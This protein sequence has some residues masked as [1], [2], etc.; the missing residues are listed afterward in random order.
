MRT[1]LI[2]LGTIVTLILV[3]LSFYS[4]DAA[5]YAYVT[6]LGRHLA[7]YDGAD[8]EDGAG[9]HGGWPWPIQ[10]VIRLDRRLQSFDLPGTE[11]LTHDPQGKT[12]DKTLTVEAFVCWKIAGA[13]GVDRFIRRMG[14]ASRARDIL[15]QRINS[16][17]GAA[18]GRM[19]MDDLIST[20]PGT[21]PGKTHVDET[22]DA[23]RAKLMSGLETVVREEYGIDLVDIRL[24]RFNHPAQVR[25]AIFDRIRSERSKKVAYYQSEGDKQAKNIESTAEEKIRNLLAEAR[26]KEEK[27]KG[28][29]D[30]E[31]VRIRNQAHSQD[32][33][34]YTFLKKLE[35]LQN[36]LTDNK[37]VLLLSSRRPIFD[38]LFQPPQPNGSVSNGNGLSS[39]SDNS[40]KGKKPASAAS[41]EGGPK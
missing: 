23:L 28:D 34:F 20:E 40:D 6:Q 7:T 26:Y 41:K 13:D 24:R 12:I 3:R 38:L 19:K 32:P 37:T 33:E 27:L 25:S 39:S 22:M 31:A 29:A 14:T 18:I 17:L 35:K 4:V 15:G 21:V 30:T 16:Q 36:I 2:L 5:E 1:F 8:Q 9:L 11:L 10:S